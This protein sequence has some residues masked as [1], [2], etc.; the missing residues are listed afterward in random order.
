MEPHHWAWQRQRAMHHVGAVRSYARDLD[1]YDL[2]GPNESPRGPC[3]R[4]AEIANTSLYLSFT[5][6]SSSHQDDDD[7]TANEEERPDRPRYI[8]TDRHCLLRPRGTLRTCI[9]YG[10]TTR[11]TTTMYY[12]VLLLN[13]I[14]RK[15]NQSI[16][17]RGTPVSSPHCL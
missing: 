15:K 10:T 8:L 4:C 16:A 2:R 14:T 5:S 6:S 12:R 11:P 1:L 7:S 13:I 9:L 3:A 17:V